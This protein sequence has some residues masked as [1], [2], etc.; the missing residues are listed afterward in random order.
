MSKAMIS[1]ETWLTETEVA[2]ITSLSLSKLRSDRHKCR[3]L[4]YYKIGKAV[5]YRLLDLKEHLETCRITPD[6]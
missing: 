1:E 2:S 5:R 3:G 4:P 6:N